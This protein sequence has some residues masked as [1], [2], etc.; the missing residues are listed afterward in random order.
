[1]ETPRLRERYIY[2]DEDVRAF[3]LSL[4]EAADLIENIPPFSGIVRD[5]NG[6]MIIACASAVSAAY[7]VTRDKDL[8]SLRTYDS[9]T[10]VTPE[11][12]MDTLRS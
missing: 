12:F 7:I 10:I 11:V 6:D 8:L 9:I 3:I 4:R 1:M 5:P 2:S